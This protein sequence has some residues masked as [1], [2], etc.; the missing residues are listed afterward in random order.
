MSL[1][2]FGSLALLLLAA[3]LSGP[4]RLLPLLVASPVLLALIGDLLMREWAL[5]VPASLLL[6]VP[7]LALLLGLPFSALRSL[8]LRRRATPRPEVPSTR[9]P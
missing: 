8:T 2:F 3:W 6:A 1:L 5:S 7:I 4:L 9:R